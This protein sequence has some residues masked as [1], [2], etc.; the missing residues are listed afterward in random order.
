MSEHL[1]D[2]FAWHLH[3]IA[4]E[5]TYGDVVAARKRLDL[6]RSQPDEAE[7]KIRTQ[8]HIYLDVVEKSQREAT[9]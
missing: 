5:Q 4:L 7:I 9:V 1:M 3:R 6:W 8:A 2:H